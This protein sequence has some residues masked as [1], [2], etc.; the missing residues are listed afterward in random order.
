MSNG[1]RP[2]NEF[3]NFE[4]VEKVPRGYRMCSPIGCPLDVYNLMKKCW[5]HVP[6]ERPLFSELLNIL[7]KIIYETTSEGLIYTDLSLLY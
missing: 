5:E 1:C 7:D 2:Y 6:T 4:V 3:S